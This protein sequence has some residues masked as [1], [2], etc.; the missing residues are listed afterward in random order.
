MSDEI[1]LLRNQ[2]P[3]LNRNTLERPL[4]YLDSAATAQ[5]PQCVL[6]AVNRHE[7][8]ARGNV[9]RGSHHLAELATLA[10]EQARLSV[11]NFLNADN[12][13]EV[14]FTSGTTASINLLAHTLGERYGPDDEILLTQAEHHSNLVPWRMLSMRTGVKLRYLPVTAEG[15]LRL[16]DLEQWV[17][18]HCRLIAV[19]HCSNVTGAVTD[20]Q[21]IVAAARV[22]DALVL[23]DGAQ[24]APHQLADVKAMGCDFYAFSGHKCFAPTG[25]GVLWGRQTLLENLPPF[26]GGGG[27]IDYIDEQCIEFASPIR[28]FEAG[29]PPIAQA[30]GLGA[31]L[32]WM[33]KLPKK[34]IYAHEQQLFG[35]LLDGLRLMKGV[36]LL[37]PDAGI[38]Q[39]PLIS[40]ELPDFHP[41]D[42]CHVLNERG[43]AIRGGHFCALPL[44]QAMNTESACRV[45]L[46]FYNDESDIDALLIGLEQA[47]RVLE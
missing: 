23:V 30:V 17:T 28:R 8:T 33:L 24:A 12:A 38:A 11:A 16:D 46:A 13:D 37:G 14:I 10:Y 20:I 26:L 6:D 5:L 29:T 45:S 3:A 22:V 39:I 27:M 43:V 42:V 4:H 31:A 35:R 18:P 9:Q 40:F 32:E 2:F 44:L 36:R 21:K 25:V 1:G 7:T 34:C 41:H 19:T 47:R 15:R